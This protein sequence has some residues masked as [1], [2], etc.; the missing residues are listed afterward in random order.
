MSQALSIDHARGWNL[1]TTLMVC[2]TVFRI[3]DLFYVA[4]SS[5]WEG[6]PESFIHEFDPFAI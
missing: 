3:D 2:T 4:L 1:A 6:D 5:E